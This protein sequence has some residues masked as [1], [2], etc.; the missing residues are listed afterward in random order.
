MRRYLLGALLSITLL[1]ACSPSSGAFVEY[2]LGVL[3]ITIDSYGQINFAVSGEFTLPFLV[4]TFRV[5]VYQNV[6]QEL[7]LLNTLTIRINGE[8]HIYDLNGQ[9][10]DIKFHSGYYKEISIQSDGRN[11]LLIVE[12]LNSGPITTDNSNVNAN[13]SPSLSGFSC[14]GAYGPHFYIGDRFYV[15]PGDGSTSVWEEPNNVPRVGYI[16]EH[17]GGI[18]TGGPV[19]KRGQEGLLVTWMVSTDNGLEGWVAEG[20]PHSP[21]PWISPLN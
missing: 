18:I 5:G 2:S 19:C 8:D 12:P 6:A 16:P 20:Y 4:G 17:G 11:L 3:S 21:I 13:L 15:P 10:L 1:V 14:P 7:G 9:D